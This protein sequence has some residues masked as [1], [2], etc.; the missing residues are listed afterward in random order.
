LSPPTGSHADTHILPL[1][2]V[3]ITLIHS[4]AAKYKESTSIVS[5]LIASNQPLDQEAFELG[6]KIAFKCSLYKKGV[7]LLKQ[8]VKQGMVPSEENV[9]LV[10][11]LCAVSFLSCLLGL[12]IYFCILIAFPSSAFIEGREMDCSR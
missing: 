4:N 6:L 11:N 2:S 1:S 7:T 5:R 12:C 10:I 3:P 9:D 8:F